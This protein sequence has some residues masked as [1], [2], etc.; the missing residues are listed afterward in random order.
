[1]SKPLHLLSKRRKLQLINK[2]IINHSNPL[3]RKEFAKSISNS[4]N[5]SIINAEST[6]DH[7]TDCNV[8]CINNDCIKSNTEEIYEINDTESDIQETYETNSIE[9]HIKELYEINTNISNLEMN[10]LCKIIETDLE[11]SNHELYDELE[12]HKQRHG[13]KEENLL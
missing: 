9:S 10:E 5:T 6:L 11:S 1:M 8:I 13:N 7:Q 2:E 4:S 3:Y 12:S